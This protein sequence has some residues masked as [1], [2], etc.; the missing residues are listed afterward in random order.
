M[1]D[2]VADKGRERL[3]HVR[4]IGG[5]SGAGKSTIAR[6]LAARHGLA[7]YSTDDVMVD[8]ARRST[9]EEAPQLSR[10]MEM[11]MDDR[12]LGQSPE[13]MLKS[14]HWFRGEG[15]DLMVEDLR[16]LPQQPGVIAEGFRLL[17]HLVA[18]LAERGRLVWLLP[19]PEFRTTAFESRGTMWDIPNSTSDP[20]SAQRA[21]L[22]RDHLFAEQLRGE[23]NELRVPFVEV[24]GS[25]DEEQLTDRVAELLG[26]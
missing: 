9:P 25:L 5:A 8:H 4:W 10:F 1:G 13:A 22:E 2:A 20:I 6:H 3:R 26:L 18:P 24:D 14:F 17:P 16:G 12:W 19:T 23:L 15:F 11:T 21:L 7:V